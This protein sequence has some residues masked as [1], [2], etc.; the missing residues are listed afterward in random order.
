MKIFKYAA[1]AAFAT[2]NERTKRDVGFSL[3]GEENPDVLINILAEITNGD[4]DEINKLSWPLWEL[5]VSKL[6]L[7]PENSAP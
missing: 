7:K 4:V 5:T 3:T 2:A 1:I 6:K